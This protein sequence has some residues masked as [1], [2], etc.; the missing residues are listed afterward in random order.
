[1]ALI[2][3]DN[4]FLTDIESLK[5]ED[6]KLPA[7]VWD[8]IADILKNTNTPLSGIGKPEALKNDLSGFFSRRITDKHRLIYKFTDGK[9]YLL[10]CYGHYSDI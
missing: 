5:K 1:M 4:L 10:S 3:V 2:E 8:L 6:R 9:L 7:K